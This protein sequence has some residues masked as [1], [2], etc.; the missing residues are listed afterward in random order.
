M[1][2]EY[3]GFM[4]YFIEFL[5]FTFAL[6]LSTSFFKTEIETKP[7]ISTSFYRI[8][9]YDSMNSNKPLMRKKGNPL[10][11]LSTKTISNY[12]LGKLYSI[13]LNYAL[14]YTL[15]PKLSECT[16]CSLHPKLSHF[17]LKC[18]F[19]CYVWLNFTS[20]DKHMLLATNLK[21]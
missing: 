3:L 17:T 6:Q 5:F 7:Y 10:F 21:N 12:I 1:C 11:F 19:C 13:T 16:L 14:N 4:L 8:S 20:Y 9:S 2:E 18:Y 15:H